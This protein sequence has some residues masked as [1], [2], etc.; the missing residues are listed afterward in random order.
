MRRICRQ[1]GFT[2][3]EIIVVIALLAIL[4]TGALIGLKRSRD[5]TAL[6]KTVQNLSA[7]DLAKQTWQRFHPND[8]WPANELDRWSAVA[9]HLNLTGAA[10]ETPAGSGYYYWA[11][12]TPEGYAYHIGSL[13]EPAGGQCNGTQITRPLD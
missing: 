1:R 4:G 2:L 11:G 13:A 8:T 5:N 6:R 10:V 9:Q 3:A 12:F 7:I